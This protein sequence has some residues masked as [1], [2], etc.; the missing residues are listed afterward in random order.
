MATKRFTALKDFKYGTRMLRA[1]DP[2]DMDGPNARLFTALGAIGAHKPAGLKG[3]GGLHE[4]L[5][6]ESP[7]E[8]T[9]L[10]AALNGPHP[11]QTSKRKTAPKKKGAVP[12]MS[13]KNTGRKAPKEK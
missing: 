12:A 9:G 10:T 1:G 7:T 5:T 8:L 6:G 13:T 2:V 11:N 3:A 4:A